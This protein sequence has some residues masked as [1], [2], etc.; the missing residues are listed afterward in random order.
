MA[1]PKLP[2]AVLLLLSALSPATE[3]TLMLL[4]LLPLI[5][6]LDISATR[7]RVLAPATARWEDCFVGAAK[8]NAPRSENCADAV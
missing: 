3:D 2:P 4:L 1:P 8:A 5:P 6:P 7:L